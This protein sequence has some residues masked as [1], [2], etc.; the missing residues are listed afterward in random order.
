MPESKEREFEEELARLI[1]EASET[2]IITN[3]TKLIKSADLSKIPET[4]DKVVKMQKEGFTTEQ[5]GVALGFPS[6]QIGLLLED[7]V[8]LGTPEQIMQASLKTLISLIPIAD[9]TYREDPK[10]N[11]ALAITGLID[12][13]K[14]IIQ[15]L[16]HMKDKEETYRVMIQKIVQPILRSMISE[17]MA[18][19]RDYA[20]TFEEN[21]MKPKL[22]DDLQQAAMNIGKKFDEAYR[23][24]NEALAMII[25]INPDAKMRVLAALSLADVQGD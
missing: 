24:S 6:D 7:K 17:M 9:R 8:E 16:Y 14:G 5:I 23:R 4:K 25:G 10:S 12:S 2:K 20:K 22:Q 3:E 21:P 15:E 18:E 11:N 13:A 1:Q 19:F